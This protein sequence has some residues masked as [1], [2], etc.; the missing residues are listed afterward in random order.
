MSSFILKTNEVTS[1]CAIF[2]LFKMLNY[3]YCILILFNLTISNISNNSIIF[4]FISIIN[5]K[6]LLVHP[7]I[8]PFIDLSF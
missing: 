3:F 5:N 8:K 7:H 2:Y 6:F 1:A 4:I